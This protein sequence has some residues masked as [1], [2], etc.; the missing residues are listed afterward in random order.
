MTYCVD[1]SQ[2]FLDTCVIIQAAHEKMMGEVEIKQ[3]LSNMGFY[4]RASPL[5]AP[6]GDYCNVTVF[7]WSASSQIMT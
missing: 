4:A 7:V 6:K 3:R 2:C 1:S 5:P